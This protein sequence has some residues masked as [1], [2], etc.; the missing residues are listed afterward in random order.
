M[1]L[2]MQKLT[3]E[4]RSI[5][6][7]AFKDPNFAYN[8]SKISYKVTEILIIGFLYCTFEKEQDHL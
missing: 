2:D 6:S 1:N 5:E 4:I 7:I 3:K 8:D